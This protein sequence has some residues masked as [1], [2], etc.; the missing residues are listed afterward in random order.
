MLF[1][2]NLESPNP[3]AV[4][5]GPAVNLAA[6]VVVNTALAAHHLSGRA[7]LS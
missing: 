5:P 2:C 6:G 4:G 7:R 3:N 1:T